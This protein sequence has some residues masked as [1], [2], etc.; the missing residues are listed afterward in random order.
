MAF[1]FIPVILFGLLFLAIGLKLSNA[2]AFGIVKLGLILGGII[3]IGWG[4]FAFW[5]EISSSL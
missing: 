5:A 2:G 3:L 4:L 1:E